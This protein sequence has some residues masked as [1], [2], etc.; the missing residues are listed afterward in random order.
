MQHTDLPEGV[1][2]LLIHGLEL[3]GA[4][5]SQDPPEELLSRAMNLYVVASEHL[6]LEEA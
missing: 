4:V 2:Q 3:A 5:M 1:R 6:E